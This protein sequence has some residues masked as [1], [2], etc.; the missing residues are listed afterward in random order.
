[1]DF[2]SLFSPQ[3]HALEDEEKGFSSE[4]MNRNLLPARGETSH[5]LCVT[6]LAISLEAF[7][8]H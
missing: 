1:M 6:F 5:A 8:F 7:S 4:E 3:F 2:T